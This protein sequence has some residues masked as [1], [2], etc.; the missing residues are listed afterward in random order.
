MYDNNMGVQTY[1]T[2]VAGWSGGIPFN[3]DQRNFFGANQDVVSDSSPGFNFGSWYNAEFEELAALIANNPG[4]DEDVI[5]EAAHRVQEIMW[6]E[7][8]YLWLYAFDSVYAAG[9]DVANFAP[10]PAQGVWNIDTWYVRQ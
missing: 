1:D 4:C 5:L 8:P 6:D 10:F 7:Q 2:A 3:P 9:P